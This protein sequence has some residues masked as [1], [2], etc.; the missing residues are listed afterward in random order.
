VSAA[1]DVNVLLYASDT[2]SAHSTRAREFLAE[3]AS[4]S[5]VLYLWWGT[6]MAYLRMATHPSIFTQPLGPAEAQANVA[7]LIQLP[8]TR[9]LHEED[10]FW[11][12]Y[13]EV[14]GSVPAR[15][16]LV[17][18]AH[19]ASILRQHGVRV[20]YTN[21]SDFRKFGFLETRNPFS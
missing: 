14:T 5:E 21:D 15:G 12:V 11:D 4:S 16:N 8:Q 13:L 1:I 9:V 17:P 2:S 20:L 19:L 18:D 6:A 10:G 3:R 7:A